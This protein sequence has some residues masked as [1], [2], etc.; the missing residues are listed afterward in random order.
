MP[1]FEFIVSTVEREPRAGHHRTP[2]YVHFQDII[3]AHG[4]HDAVGVDIIIDAEG[5][6]PVLRQRLTDG[7]GETIETLNYP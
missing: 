5:D 1:P 7:T 6:D 3:P 4:K 2:A